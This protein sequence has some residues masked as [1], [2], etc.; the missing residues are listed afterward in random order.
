[1]V[2][3]F[4][5][6]FHIFIVN[7]PKWDWFFCVY[8]VSVT[9]LTSR[10]GS[11]RFFKTIFWDF[12]TENHVVYKTGTVEVSLSHVFSFAY[13]MARI[14][15]TILNKSS[16]SKLFCLRPHKGVSPVQASRCLSVGKENWSHRHG[17]CPCLCAV[18]SLP[19]LPRCL[20][21]WEAHLR[22]PGT[23]S[24]VFLAGH[25]LSVW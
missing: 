5:F 19:Q 21:V 16:E 13:L 9:L 6:S 20:W 22:F 17:R 11:M 1:M 12:Y 4:N 10:P 3:C 14:S 2:L 15:C 7:I 23:K 8:L 24:L 25:L 18:L